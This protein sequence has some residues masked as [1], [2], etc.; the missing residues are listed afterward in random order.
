MVA[1]S[2]DKRRLAEVG[3]HKIV[4]GLLRIRHEVATVAVRVVVHHKVTSEQSEIVAVLAAHGLNSLHRARHERPRRITHQ[5]APVV[6]LVHNLVIR[7]RLVHNLTVELG[8]VGTVV[9]AAGYRGAPGAVALTS[10]IVARVKM[11]VGQ[12]NNAQVVLRVVVLVGI[13]T[14]LAPP[15]DDVRRSVALTTEPV[16]QKLL[17][18]R[19]IWLVAERQ[20]REL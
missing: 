12:V 19:Y 17:R 1:K 2:W 3:L 9:V 14:L 4:L 16:V 20:R 7:Q 13:V 6:G 15:A 18:Q 5:T 10:H 8:K 11:Q